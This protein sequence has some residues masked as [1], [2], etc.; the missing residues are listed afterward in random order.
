[1]LDQEDHFWTAIQLAPVEERDG[2]LFKE[3]LNRAPVKHYVRALGNLSCGTG[4]VWDPKPR[5]N[6]LPWLG[7]HYVFQ[8][9]LPNNA[10]SGHSAKSSFWP[11]SQRPRNCTWT[12]SRRAGRKKMIDGMT[13]PPFCDI[14]VQDGFPGLVGPFEYGHVRFGQSVFGLNPNGNN[15]ECLRTIE[16][17]SHGTIPVHID[18]T[19]LHKTF[20]T[21]PG[22]IAK[23]WTE[24]RQRMEQLL[25]GPPEILDALQDA[26]LNWFVDHATCVRNDLEIILSIAMSTVHTSTPTREPTLSPTNDSIE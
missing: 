12:G 23:N 4:P 1:L 15:P 26:S 24:A 11:S 21:V 8:Q 20:R 3:E 25:S 6:M 13:N 5:N 10:M 9:G 18:S 16:M 19:Y 2:N 22:I 17:L 7:I 14:D